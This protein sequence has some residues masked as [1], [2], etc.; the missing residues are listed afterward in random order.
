M[1]PVLQLLPAREAFYQRI[2]RSDGHVGAALRLLGRGSAGE[3]LF[4]EIT[5]MGLN[6]QYCAMCIAQRYTPPSEG[7]PEVPEMALTHDSP[8]P[9]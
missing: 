2:V 8:R 9:K 6:L 3:S 4:H 1:R 5:M 7:L